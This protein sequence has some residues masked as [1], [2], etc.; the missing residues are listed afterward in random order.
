ML[1]APFRRTT[2]RSAGACLERE[3]PLPAYDYVL[4]CSHAF[5]LLDARGAISVTERVG[6]IARVR[7]LARRRGAR[8]RCEPRRSRGDVSGPA[9]LIEL[10]TEELPAN[11]CAAARMQAGEIVERELRAERRLAPA[12]VRALVAPRRIAVLA[13]GVPLVQAA[14]TTR[15]SR[16]RPSASRTRRGEH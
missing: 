13:D 6:Y 1:R 7:D 10:G 11:A 8:A 5:N 16:A 15:A 4:K 14:E 2:R 12:G 3:L 9:L